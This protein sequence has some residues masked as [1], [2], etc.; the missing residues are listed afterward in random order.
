V[1]IDQET[2]KLNALKSDF[3]NVVLVSVRGYLYSY[4]QR[5]TLNVGAS[6]LYFV[7]QA[8]E[9]REREEY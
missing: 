4:V 5:M 3:W 8:S 6:S 9:H 2:G 1:R 7:C